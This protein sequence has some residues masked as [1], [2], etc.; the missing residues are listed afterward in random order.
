MLFSILGSS[1]LPVVVAQ[2]DERHANRTAYVLERGMT[3]T[4]H[5]T[6]SSNEEDLFEDNDKALRKLFKFHFIYR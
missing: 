6:S 2:P 1:S 3:Y 4:E 5:S